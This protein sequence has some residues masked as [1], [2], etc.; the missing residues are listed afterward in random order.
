VLWEAQFGDFANTA[1]CII[2]QFISSGEMKWLR[3]T[4]LVMLLPHGYEGMG[5]EHSSGRLERFLQMSD[6][7]PYFFPKINPGTGKQIQAT[8]W[9]IVNCSTAANYFHVL[10]RQIYRDFRKPLVCMTG[11]FTLRLRE[12]TS[13]IDEMA[14]GTRF[15]RV[16]AEGHGAAAEEDLVAPSETKRLVLCSGKVYYDLLRARKLNN[17]KDVALIRVEQLSP[18]PFDLVKEQ[19]DLYAGAEVV[20]CQEEPKNQ[21]GWQYVR[22]RIET[23]SRG[24]EGNDAPRLAQYTGRATA[25]S[26]A[27]GFK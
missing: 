3:Q 6:D 5:P 25:A 15:Q 22:P 7:D 10:R 27:T 18:F 14:E 16:I 1:Q 20:W 11:K 4:G 24:L 2:D 21:G 26:T 13:T 9:Q 17:I 23:A 19:L 12:A 8:N